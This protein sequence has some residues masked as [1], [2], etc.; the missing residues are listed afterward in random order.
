MKSP[1]HQAAEAYAKRGIAVF[2]IVAA[3]TFKR[4][5]TDHGLLDATTDLT[6]ISAWWSSRPDFNVGIPTGAAATFVVV[7][8][9]G[10]EGAASLAA[11]E[12]EHGA[13]PETPEQTTARG[14]HICFAYDPERPIRNSASRHPRYG[15]DPRAKID[16]RGDGGYI[17]A[18]P[19][20]H[21]SGAVYAWHAERRPSKMPFAAMPEWLRA[22]LEWKPSQ[23]P[24]LAVVPS[25]PRAPVQPGSKLISAY[26]EAALR[27]ECHKITTSTP[28][29][30]E[31]TLNTSAFVIGSLVGG[32]EITESIARAA[33]VDAAMA[34]ARDW[35][36]TDI[37]EKVERA[38]SAGMLSPR[39]A[40]EPTRT[41]RPQRPAPAAI[42]T[43]QAETATIVDIRQPDKGYGADDAWERELIRK[44]DGGS[45]A[46]KYK[47]ALILLINHP[48]LRGVF[49]FNMFSRSV[50]I[51]R[52]PH[53]DEDDGT[54]WEQRSLTDRDV[55]WATA[56]LETKGVSKPTATIH[57][58]CETAAYA[59]P[60]NPAADW[61]CDLKWD[62]S[63]RLSGWLTHYMGADPSPY[64]SAVGRKWLIGAVARVLSPG[65]K[66]DT[67]LILEGH[68][69]L[70]KSKALKILGTFGRASYFTDEISDIGSKDAA[71]QLQGV[72]IVE[73]AELSGLEK[74]V[75]ALKAWL[76]RTTDRY[77]PPYGRA[78]IEAPR[79][80]ILG[81][82]YNPD[83]GGYMRDSTG[84][85]RF[86][87]V[88]VKSCDHESLAK[89]QPQLW[90]EAVAAYRNKESWWLDD[91]EVIAESQ[92][93]QDN[94]YEDDAWS[95]TIDEHIA[96]LAQV[97]TASIMGEACLSLPS[98]HRNQ[99][100]A[101]RIA[102]HLKRR[103][104]SR[105][106][107]Y[108]HALKTSAWVFVKPNTDGIF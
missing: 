40:P 5:A 46:N 21:A 62:G 84:A 23:A 78:L 90:A 97:T 53:W 31:V 34:I 17:V 71:M 108:D 27:D 74:D 9:D 37:S 35:T 101:S 95:A 76:T 103:G 22:I 54:E 1:T 105:T 58:A 47:N 94:R 38:M 67:M 19:S 7:D 82:S 28:G 93:E 15:A 51:C 26:G 96:R 12:A 10:P 11:M 107:R 87:P 55:A 59:N 8:V 100:T 16:V 81:G 65:C 4:P 83:G 68:Q 106:K 30:Q 56:W 60:F 75:N 25:A 77:R 24:K 48:D 79:Q 29:N 32:G 14:R 64:V 72:V 50:V 57:G 98:A 2:P 61:L 44:D 45:I 66:M 86:W 92:V 36:V 63:Q 80:C 52:R 18:A 42:T 69:G 99:S 43:Q 3:D 13:L 39:S 88:L 41:A 89:D 91:D 6:K 102:K 70:G 33:L 85:R 20:K 73:L 104:W 49:G